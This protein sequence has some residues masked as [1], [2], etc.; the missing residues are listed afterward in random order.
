MNPMIR[1]SQKGMTLVE[2]L[3]AS[4]VGLLVMALAGYI[5]KRQSRNYLDMQVQ[6]DL[7][8]QMKKGQQ[9]LT[10]EISNVGAG[11]D[12]AAN[13]FTM[14]SNRLSFSFIDLKGRH[15]AAMD[16]VT[17]TF[18]IASTPPG[19][20]LIKE[21]KCGGSGATVAESVMKCDSAKLEFWYIKPDRYTTSVPSE[22]KMIQYE[23]SVYSKN[24]KDLFD[25]NRLIRVQVWLGAT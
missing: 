5:F 24:S 18:R 1:P 3:I 6:S 10:R 17:L 20:S 2:I 12:P 9:M 8:A 7:Q 23:L 19:Q 4:A 21:R 25:R 13:P 22:V 11:M 16:T 15:C 14:H